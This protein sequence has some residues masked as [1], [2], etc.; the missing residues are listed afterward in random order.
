M[1]AGFAH[2]LGEYYVAAG[3]AYREAGDAYLNQGDCVA[4]ECCY[5][6]AQYN[7]DY[8]EYLGGGPE[9]NQPSCT[10]GTTGQTDGTCV[11][12]FDPNIRHGDGDGF[13]LDTIAEAIGDFFLEVF[14]TVICVVML[15]LSV[16]F[17]WI[18][19]GS[20]LYL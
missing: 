15:G 20:C 12:P 1:V 13:G 14:A 6:W 18:D 17:P 4:A 10:V 11:S 9:P 7:Y 16:V 19:T 5:D 3:D 2:G 8:A